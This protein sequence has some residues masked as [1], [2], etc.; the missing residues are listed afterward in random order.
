MKLSICLR[1]S[2]RLAAAA[3]ALLAV[4]SCASSTT[5]TGR[6]P[7]Y[8]IINSLTAASGAQ[9][10]TFGT[11]LN[12]DVQTLVSQT[13][14]GAQV[15]V[16]TIF[17]DLGQAS[18]RMALKNE[19]SA[20]SPTSPSEANQIT[21]TRYHVEYKRADNRNAPGVDVPFGFDGGVTTTVGTS[22]VTFNFDLVRHT[23][24]EEPPLRNLVSG[25]GL[26]EIHTIAEVTFYGKDQAGNEVSVTGL[27]TV[28][29]ADFG[30]PS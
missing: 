17:N 18:V 19:G 6:S 1:Q 16:P 9:A 27:I 28:N 2:S 3:A 26:G 24:K 23:Q 10:G 7:A 25:G 20:G 14:N 11:Q 30:D 5:R 8:L 29:F 12:S 21:I 15:K 13:V 22:A 4:S